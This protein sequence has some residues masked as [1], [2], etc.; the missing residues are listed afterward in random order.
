[1]TSRTTIHG[2]AVDSAI[3]RFLDE[4]VLPAVGVDV[5]HFWRGFDQIVRDLSPRN[6]ALLA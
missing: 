4:E 5:A 6:A 1:M 3:K 2:L